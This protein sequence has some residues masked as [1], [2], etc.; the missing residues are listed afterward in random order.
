[1]PEL[2]AAPR[3][4]PP[5]IHGVAQATAFRVLRFEHVEPDRTQIHRLVHLQPGR[6]AHQRW[7]ELVEQLV[8]ESRRLVRARGLFR[9]DPVTALE[10]RRITLASGAVFDGAVGAFLKHAQYMATFVV[11]IGSALERLS[12]A[13]LKAGK[14]MQGTIADAIASQSVE[15]AGDLLAAEVRAWARERGLDTTPP[16]S[17]GYCGM[18]VRQ[19]VPLFASVPAHQI[20][21]RVTPSCLMLPVKSISGLIGL[22]PA[23]LV[24]PGGYPCE[25]CTHPDCMQRRAPVNHAR[26]QELLAR[27]PAA[28]YHGSA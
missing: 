13:W 11:T 10:G 9:I 3:S 18:T 21:V 14:V 6:P 5:P 8:G 25:A 17:P 23:E 27:D 28:N 7:F 4:V 1:M 26:L 12:R 20:N 24:S 15:A 16:Y 19:Q 2:S 22:G